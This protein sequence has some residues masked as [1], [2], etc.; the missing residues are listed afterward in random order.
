MS[1][2]APKLGFASVRSSWRWD[3]AWPVFCFFGALLAS[4]QAL[5]KGQVIKQFFAFSITEALAKNPWNW[6]S[7]TLPCVPLRT[8]VEEP[9]VFHFL[10]AWGLKIWPG[11]SALIPALAFSLLAWLSLKGIRE[12]RLGERDTWTLAVLMATVPVFLRYSIQHLPDLLATA[13]LAWGAWALFRRKRL[14]AT[15]LFTL[16]VTAKA[17]TGVAVAS[18]LFWEFWIHFRPQVRT[19]ADSGR[20][21]VAVGV[22]LA[23]IA[24]PFLIWVIVVKRAG[25]P[26]PFQFGSVSE[27]RHS[28]G[29]GLLLSVPY[30]SR[31]F[32]W[33]AVKGI[34]LPLFF[35]ALPAL[36]RI[37]REKRLGGLDGMLAAWALSAVP[38]WLLVRQGNFVHDY[39]TLPIALPWALLGCR[40]FAAGL[41]GRHRPWV[42]VGVGLQLLLALLNFRGLRPMVLSPDQERPTYCEMEQNQAD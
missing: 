12:W 36:F 25:I 18:L 33:L 19:R 16:A 6:L 22:R 10:G 20:G 2:P 39:Y 37:L 9:P 11:Q 3:W 40:A 13:F 7:T 42:M 23:F 28:G 14:W 32:T 4:S 1:D 41:G 38:Y 8:W 35:A 5:L 21:L 15:V 34:G 17:L 29:F 24:L 30:W 26:S 27:N 31:L